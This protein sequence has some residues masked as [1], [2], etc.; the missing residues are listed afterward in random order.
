MNT[1]FLSTTTVRSAALLM[2]ALNVH[3]SDACGKEQA[4]PQLL[5]TLKETITIMEDKTLLEEKQPEQPSSDK[6]QEQPADEEAAMPEIGAE[7]V[8]VVEM[9]EAPKMDDKP[10]SKLPE[11]KELKKV[12]VVDMI[13]APKMDDKPKSKLMQ[14]LADAESI[15]AASIKAVAGDEV[16]AEKDA[17]KKVEAD[18]TSSTEIEEESDLDKALKNCDNKDFVKGQYVVIADPGKVESYKIL[19]T[20]GDYLGV[21]NC[22]KFH[23]FL[24]K[25]HD[26]NER[27]FNENFDIVNLKVGHF[28]RYTDADEI[29]HYALVSE[30]GGLEYMVECSKGLTYD[31]YRVVKQSLLEDVDFESLSK[32]TGKWQIH[33]RHDAESKFRTVKN[34][35][36]WKAKRTTEKVT[37]FSTKVEAQRASK[38]IGYQMRRN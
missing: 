12:P 16:N 10:K 17:S 18:E 26:E 1:K 28:A 15:D 24:N 23:N 3:L 37:M 7:K 8:P 11:I 9:I 2:V 21:R 14:R 31:G 25:R 19:W 33:Y 35:N 22:G 6:G 29:Q 20:H 30:V 4:V 34:T 27:E 36:C 38:K 32:Y 13:E 5:V